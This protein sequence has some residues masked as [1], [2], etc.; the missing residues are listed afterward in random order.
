MTQEKEILATLDE[1]ADAYCTK[2]LDRLMAIFDTGDD[3]SVIGTGADELCYGQSEIRA[4]FARNFAEATADR[5]AWDWTKVTIRDDSAVVA[6]TLT[7]H[8]DLDGE[9]LHVPIRWTV[10]LKQTEG[11]WLWL[12]RNASAS[13]GG[14]EE[15][16][17]Y[18]TD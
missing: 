16:E 15:G 18:P 8:I 17:A 4:L 12:H 11:K 3:I 2:D 13:A 1:Y 5:F 10:V 6:I 9:K 7:I 14:Q